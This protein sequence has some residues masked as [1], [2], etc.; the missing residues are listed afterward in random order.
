MDARTSGGKTPGRGNELLE[1][2]FGKLETL[3]AI[4]RDIHKHPELGM[5]ETRT[6]ALIAEHLGK[7]GIEVETGVAGTGVVGLLRGTDRGRTVA[8]R[9]DIDALAMQE[10]T[11]SSFA[12]KV[13]GVAHTCGHDAHTA[14]QLGAAMLLTERRDSF[15]GNVK[16]IFQPSEDTLPGGA[17]P[18]IE[19]GVLKKPRVD[20]I[21]SLHLYPQFEQGTVAVK[22]GEASTSSTSFTLTIRG[23]GG[24]VGMPHKVLNPILLAALVMTNTQS[25]LA[26]KLAPGQPLIF[27]FASIHGG[28][29]GNV[30]PPEIVLQGSIRVSSP[31]QLEL[32]IR[33]FETLIRGVVEAAGGSYTLD[34]QK[35]YPTI[36]NDPQLVALL[37]RAAQ[38]VVGERQVIEYDRIMT[39]GDDAAY[40]Q[41]RVPGVYWWLGIAN[42][43][44][45][46]N[47]PLHS[48]HFDFNEEVLAVGAA[49]QAQT[50]M[51]FLE[52][53]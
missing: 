8:L 13:P 31:E 4:R 11:S 19:A 29:V 21:F 14:I 36:M 23:T 25:M 20:A 52:T 46:F 2:A 38:K 42:A 22:S 51:D 47:Q 12:S 30:V 5:Q 41:Q 33:S 15:A 17:L 27:E 35:G 37:K 53:K 18:M 45:G 3:R 6:A 9:A 7:L 48:P 26:K 43:E 44:N 32:M 28:T 1:S 40:F 50:V 39:G 34:T 10:L 24:H 49:V 16:F